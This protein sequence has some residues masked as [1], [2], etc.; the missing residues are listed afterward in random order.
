MVSRSFGFKGGTRSRPGDSVGLE[1]SW[2][3]RML[4]SVICSSDTLVVSSSSLLP[5]QL[6]SSKSFTGCSRL[7]LGIRIN[8]LLG[9]FFVKLG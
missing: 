9:T 1:V 7:L 4:A 3:L 2:M 5:E 8:R 6:I